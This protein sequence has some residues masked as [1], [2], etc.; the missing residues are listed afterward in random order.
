MKRF[1]GLYLL[2]EDFHQRSAQVGK[3]KA[4]EAIEIKAGDEIIFRIP[5]QEGMTR[6]LRP[7]YERDKASL[8]HLRLAHHSFDQACSTCNQIRMIGHRHLRIVEAD[9]PGAVSADLAGPISETRAG[10][11]YL[12][13]V[14]KRSTRY[15]L[16]AAIPNKRSETVKAAMVDFKLDLRRIWRFHS[17]QGGELDGGCDKWLRDNIIIHTTTGGYEPQQNG[18]AESHVGVVCGGGR[19]LL[20]QAGAPKSLWSE[21]AKHY[22]EV[23]NRIKRRITGQEVEIQPLLAEMKEADDVT[24]WPPW[25]CKAFALL[26]RV[27]RDD[28]VSPVAVLGTFLGFEKTVSNGTRVA[29]LHKD[30]TKVA[31]PIEDV[32][33]STTVRRIDGHFPLAEGP[34][35]DE[36]LKDFLK[37]EEKRALKADAGT[38]DPDAVASDKG[39]QDEVRQERVDEESKAFERRA[40][41]EARGRRSRTPAVLRQRA[42][43]AKYFIRSQT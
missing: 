23:K 19:A 15:G 4:T 31:D 29:V 40:E 35:E 42:E 43:R 18:I 26:P 7:H 24:K 11:V 38:P 2:E 22:N 41:T 3:V 28:K 8:E 27:H 37:E 10:S 12:M 39:A 14:V 33:V 13:V 21:A 16:V 36:C 9:S 5:K 20:H 25:G 6:E 17:D 32:L 1:G 30:Y 34:R